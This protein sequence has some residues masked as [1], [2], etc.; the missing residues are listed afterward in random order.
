MATLVTKYKTD[1]VKFMWSSYDHAY[2]TGNVKYMF[3][4][5][6]DA[7]NTSTCSWN[8]TTACTDV[9]AYDDTNT[10]TVVWGK[11]HKTLANPAWLYDL[12]GSLSVRTP[13][14]SPLS[15]LQKI[16]QARQSPLIISSRKHIKI[17]DNSQELRARETLRRI[18]GE[19]RYQR[20]LKD[21]FVTIRGRSGK[22]YQVF[23]NTH[24]T[25]VYLDGEMI[26][27]LCVVLKGNFPPTD[28]LIMR[29]LLI[30]NDEEDFRRHAIVHRAISNKSRTNPVDNRPLTEIYR[31]IIKAA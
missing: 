5:H 22:T 21:G 20:F 30:L 8:T 16:I 18:L 27:R 26:E 6:D 9:F 25:N 1:N 24:F 19:D 12:S 14:E 17:T 23:P 15:R 3:W 31:E 2:S 28:S 4:S 11:Y 13:L 7:Y 10:D 29:Y